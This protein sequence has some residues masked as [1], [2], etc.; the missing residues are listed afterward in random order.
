MHCQVRLAC[1]A[2]GVVVRRGQSVTTP[3]VACLTSATGVTLAS[4]QRVD[5]SLPQHA[6][7]AVVGQRT[8]SPEATA[9]KL[10]ALTLR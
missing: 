1:G 9:D 7:V 5:T 10:I 3:I 6:V 4:P 2:T 8:M